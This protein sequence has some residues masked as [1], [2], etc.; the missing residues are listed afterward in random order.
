MKAWERDKGWTDRHLEYAAD[1]IYK[2]T[3]KFVSEA[4]IYADQTQAS[5]LVG[6]D[7]TRVA[8][9]IRSAKFRKFDGDFVIRESRQ[10]DPFRAELYK[11]IKMAKSLDAETDYYYFYAYIDESNSKITSFMVLDL[12]VFR[13]N[14][15]DALKN[16]RKIERAS[17]INPDQTKMVVFNIEDFDKS[18]VVT[19]K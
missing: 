16:S 1:E 8:V 4:D 19:K 3:G 5:D 11:L 12:K 9:R 18:L 13:K 7:G 2:I 15:I 17:F 14:Y 10:G 6:D